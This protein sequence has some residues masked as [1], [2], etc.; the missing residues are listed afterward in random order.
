MKMAGR[1]WKNEFGETELGI[2]CD[3]CK[4]AIY[5]NRA[6]VIFYLHIVRQKPHKS[7]AYEFCSRRCLMEWL[8]PAVGMEDILL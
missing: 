4:K 2:K 6:K 3:T 1:T 5:R 7:T 8:D